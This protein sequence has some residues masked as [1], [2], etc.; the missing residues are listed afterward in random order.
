MGQSYTEQYLDAREQFTGQSLNQLI[1]QERAEAFV[2]TYAKM[3]QEDFVSSAKA[4]Y[5]DQFYFN[6]TLAHLASEQQL[7][8]YFS[9]MNTRVVEASVALKTATFSQDS[10]Y[11]HWLMEY[12]LMFWGSSKKISSSGISELK[13]NEEGQIIFQ[14]DFWDPNNGLLKQMPYVGRWFNAIL[15][16]KALNSEG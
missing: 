14:Q 1:A 3:G 8:D 2:N 15:P 12:E 13:Y 7:T 10:L 5:A 11:V 6:D 4:L 9:S 16:F